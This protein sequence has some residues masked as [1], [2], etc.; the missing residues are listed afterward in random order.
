ML[1][2]ERMVRASWIFWSATTADSQAAMLA[3]EREP[4][5][6]LGDSMGL[7]QSV[8]EE[9][10]EARRFSSLDVGVVKVGFDA[11]EPMA[12]WEE[13]WLAEEQTV[14]NL[15]LNLAE[16]IPPTSGFV[17]NPQQLGSLWDR[18]Y[19]TGAHSGFVQSSDGIRLDPTTRE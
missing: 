17:K 14:P 2:W 15:Q 1:V 16:Q 9:K 19:F 10:L 6:D 11:V 4:S 7:V 5:E 18:N 12:V 13:E 3:R 8:R